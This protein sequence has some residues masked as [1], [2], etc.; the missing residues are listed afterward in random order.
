MAG[1]SV[2]EIRRGPEIFNGEGEIC[3]RQVAWMT[4]TVLWFDALLARLAIRNAPLGYS[5]IFSG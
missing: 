2:D 5:L 3:P 4:S 1:G